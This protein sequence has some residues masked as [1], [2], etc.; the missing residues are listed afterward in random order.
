MKKNILLASVWLLMLCLSLPVFATSTPAADDGK[1]YCVKSQRFAA[2]TGPWWTFNATN[3]I[4][5][6]LTKA[7]NQQF[8]LVTT[9]AGKVTI[10]EK[11]SSLFLTASVGTF[12]LTKPTAGWTITPN[13]VGGV[14]GTAFPGESQGIHQGAD[15]WS[16]Q[17]RAD[18]WYDLTDFCTFFFYEVKADLDL[19]IAIDAAIALKSAATVGTNPGQ[20]PQSAH[21]TYQTAINTAKLTLGSTDAT[22]LQ[23]ALDA[24]AT[25]TTTFN[26]AKI[27]PF[28]TAT[29]VADDGKWYYVKS[30]RGGSGLFWTFGTKISVGALTK[31]ENQKF[32]LVTAAT[33]KVKIKEKVTSSM[34]TAAGGVFSATGAATGWTQTPNTVNGIIGF[35]FPG[36]D[37]GLHQGN[38]GWNWEVRTSYYSLGDNCT[39]FFYEAKEDV[40]LVM[41]VETAL[42][43]LSSSSAGTTLG[44]TPQAAIDTYRGAINIAKTTIGSTDPTAIQNAINSLASATSTFIMAK[45]QPIDK[46]TAASPIW[47]LIKNTVR[48]GSKG[49]TLYT[50]G[51]NAQLKC[52]TPADMVKADG[53]ST[54]AA[55]PGLKHLFRFEQKSNGDF[56]IVNA[57]LPTGE[58][59]QTA[60]GGNSSQ[61]IKYGT[62]A[63]PVTTWKVNF[64]GTNGTLGVD[65]LTF[66]ST[67]VATMFHDDASNS[68]VSYNGGTGTA[69][70]WYVEKYTGNISALFQTQFDDLKAQYDAIA[71]VSGTPVAPYSMGTEPGQYDLV[72]FDELKVA[73]AAMVTEQTNNGVN[74]ANMIQKFTDLTVAITAFKATKVQPTVAYGGTILTNK[75]YTLKLVQPGSANNGY[76]LANPRV[77][78]NNGTD[79]SKPQ[80][81][82]VA[83]LDNGTA[84]TYWKFTASATA[85][86]YIITSARKSNEYIDEESRVR[87]ASSYGDIDWTYK[88][89]LQNSTVYVDG[90][91][92][93]IVKIDKNGN[94]LRTGTAAAATL[95]RSTE[96]STFKL[97]QKDII[98]SNVDAKTELAK[99]YAI[100]GVI[101]V[102][103]TTDFNVFTI[104]GS[105]VKNEN[106]K[107]GVYFVKSTS[108]T[109]KVFVK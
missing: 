67:G 88:T 77:D 51:F 94:F 80:A 90:T 9:V 28:S 86:K 19:N 68:L 74:S 65:E 16:W 61:V 89:L 10:Q 85:G 108:D 100:N 93:L 2:G 79:A 30:Q 54:G 37:A 83:D 45:I 109:F 78:A 59:L 75:T 15:S 23:N 20:T 47:Y 22:A 21:D 58:L 52:T 101:K 18:D 71:D 62:V 38:A 87:D 70:A 33:G 29:P 46:S 14:A 44:K 69:S 98:S 25:A 26:N 60:N 107:P 64:I 106:L 39:F 4:P 82:F 34:L 50:N 24:L 99:A 103:N 95:G 41:A 97:E 31:A 104:S 81:T 5:G 72:K 84:T 57:A 63:N 32:T 49:A 8:T 92:L 35:A 1:W 43:T 17:V 73:Y 53:T 105:K 11:T 56:Q 7:D 3:V 76:Y 42:I 27:S 55:A 48:G 91:T 6:A 102:T 96:W 40:D 36:E 66:V 12:G 13:T